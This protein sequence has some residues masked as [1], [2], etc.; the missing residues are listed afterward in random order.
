M[1]YLS[2]SLWGNKP[3]YNVG[4]IKNAQ[5]WKEVYSDWQMIVYFDNT[6]PKTTIDE[7]VDLGVK[8]ISFEDITVYGMFWRFFALNISDCE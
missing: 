2:F 8:C 4:A 6:V 5:L 1:K 3:I 7:L